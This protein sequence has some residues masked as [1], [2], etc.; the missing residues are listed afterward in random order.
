MLSSPRTAKNFLRTVS[1]QQPN[2]F[3]ANVLQIICWK[4]SVRYFSILLRTSA[5]LSGLPCVIYKSRTAGW[6]F[7]MTEGETSAVF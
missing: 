5:E 7:I 6:D 4:M 3:S 2:F 1:I